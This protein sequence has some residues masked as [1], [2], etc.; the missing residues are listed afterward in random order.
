MSPRF[1]A[2]GEANSFGRLR[3]GNAGVLGASQE[4][5]VGAANTGG[6]NAGSW[7][8]RYSRVLCANRAVPVIQIGRGVCRCGE[9]VLG[10]CADLGCQWDA[11]GRIPKV[12]RV[13]KPNGARHRV[14][15]D[16]PGCLA[17]SFMEK[18]HER[19]R[20]NPLVVQ[21]AAFAVRY[22]GVEDQSNGSHRPEL[23]SESDNGWC[24]RRCSPS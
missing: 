8:A 12:G 2:F 21:E 4:V 9:I 16:A 11:A 14:V 3:I 22:H 1:F 5:I 23:P 20:G 17:R 7:C 13:A 18:E 6:G 15:A 19:V 24:A 10:R